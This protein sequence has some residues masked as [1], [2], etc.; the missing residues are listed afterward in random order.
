MY[1]P[2]GIQQEEN[3]EPPSRA[4]QQNPGGQADLGLS[5]SLEDT[6]PKMNEE[7]MLGSLVFREHFP[8]EASKPAEHKASADSDRPLSGDIF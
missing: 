1:H 6:G 2:A 5:T 4:S 7:T 8:V 3:R